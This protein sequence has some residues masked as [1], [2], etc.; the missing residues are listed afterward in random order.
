MTRIFGKKSKG[1]ILHLSSRKGEGFTLI[2][3]LVVI[4]IIAIIVSVSLVVVMRYRDKAKNT[5]IATSLVQ[6]R[7]IA[8]SICTD[9]GSYES[10]CAADKT[11]NESYSSDLKVIENDVF[12]FI[13]LYPDCYAS[14]NSYCVQSKLIRGG[15]YCVDS[16]GLAVEI[17]DSYCEAG[18]IKCIA[19]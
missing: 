5:R 16:S 11:I 17:S 4:A 14:P 9:E 2:E 3:L 18:N 6:V 8:A 1:F 7:N 13:G 15:Y 10:I 19:P 12:K